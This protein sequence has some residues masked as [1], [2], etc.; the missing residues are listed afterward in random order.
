LI[1]VGVDTAAAVTEPDHPELS[2]VATRVYA[3][4]TYLRTPPGFGV[5]RSEKT[6]ARQISKQAT[7]FGRKTIT[8]QSRQLPQNGRFSLPH[9]HAFYGLIRLI[10]WRILCICPSVTL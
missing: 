8:D 7:V 1:R 10:A 6:S 3:Q 9:I 4:G 5:I 2:Y